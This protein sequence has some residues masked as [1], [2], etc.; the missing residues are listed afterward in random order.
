MEE[1][2]LDLL[3]GEGKT[4]EIAGQLLQIQKM[5]LRRLLAIARVSVD[6]VVD[7]GVLSGDDPQKMHDEQFNIVNT[8]AKKCARILAL[9]FVE[10]Y[11]NAAKVDE[12]ED[13]I[14]DNIN[15]TE[16]KTMAVDIIGH[17]D[18]PNFIASTLIM[19]SRVTQVTKVED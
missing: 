19:R 9:A 4:Y 12:M 3:L 7:E 18:L 14:L 16:L 2:E 1:K 5:N 13:F 8:N 17:A 6:I 10:D 15:A 11:K